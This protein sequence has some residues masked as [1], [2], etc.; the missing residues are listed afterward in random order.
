M[1]EKEKK[2]EEFNPAIDYLNEYKKFL[3]RQLD[4]YSLPEE[5]SIAIDI[6]ERMDAITDIVSILKNGYDD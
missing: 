5:V 6:A 3:S 1:N 2:M 4:R